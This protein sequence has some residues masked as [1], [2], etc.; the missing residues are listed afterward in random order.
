[1]N[2]EPGWELAENDGPRPIPVAHPVM[3]RATRVALVL[4][5]VTFT[6]VFATAAWIRPYDA[7]GK[8][9][10]MAT[11]TQLGLPECNMV[12]A[13]GKPCPSCGLTTSFAL[14][15]H[16]DVVNSLKANW[17][18]TLLAVFWLGLIPWGVVSAFR[19]RFVWVRNAELA[20]TVAVGVALALLL[21]R[22]GWILLIG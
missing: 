17:V 1:M 21:G 5:A 9:K 6:A 14:L 10:A 2:P 12:V 13:T 4:M 19:G 7:A 16:G 20:A 8:A 22:W 3:K 18:G 11:H 15:A